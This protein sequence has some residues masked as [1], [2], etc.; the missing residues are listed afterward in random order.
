M[1][2]YIKSNKKKT[3]DGKKKEQIRDEK[4]NK[5]RRNG[6]KEET[7]DQGIGTCVSWFPHSPILF[8]SFLLT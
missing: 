1:N 3:K 7:K 6:K 5:P 2:E 8:G 4:S